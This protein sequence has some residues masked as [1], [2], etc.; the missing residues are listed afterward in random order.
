MQS[1]MS[2]R[3][4]LYE[5]IFVARLFAQCVLLAH[6]FSESVLRS[7]P[8]SD[9]GKPFCYCGQRHLSD[10]SAAARVRWAESEGVSWSWY[11]DKQAYFHICQPCHMEYF[12]NDVRPEVGNRNTRPAASLWHN[13]VGGNV[14]RLICGERL[15]CSSEAG[16]SSLGPRRP[17]CCGER[18]EHPSSSGV[19]EVVLL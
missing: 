6:I 16:F 10:L 3:A 4:C 11:S 15:A 17:S 14:S 7:K 1:M 9:F 19:F 18:S 2:V 12:P 8:R 13:A 5:H